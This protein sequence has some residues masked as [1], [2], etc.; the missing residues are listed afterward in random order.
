MRP[1]KSAYPKNL[2]RLHQLQLNE[3]LQTLEN[4]EALD[5]LLHNTSS[6]L[7]SLDYQE[8]EMF[9]KHFG[10]L[11]PRLNTLR[12][13][14]T[15]NIYSSL[16]VTSGQFKKDI[17]SRLPKNRRLTLDAL[18]KR[19]AASKLPGDDLDSITPSR[20]DAELYYFNT[21][22][23]G[24]NTPQDNQQRFEDSD[25]KSIYDVDSADLGK[26]QNRIIDEKDWSQLRPYYPN[27]RIP[28]VVRR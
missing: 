8:K 25:N 21:T 26:R 14:I 12:M 1:K 6:V 17:K 7:N 24:G 10:D 27:T 15:D 11:L 13:N 22:N 20:L 5:D 2:I 4:L 23:S 16:W 9:Y 3:M 19:E 18:L 28:K